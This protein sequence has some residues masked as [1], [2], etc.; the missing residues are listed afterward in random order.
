MFESNSFP[1]HLNDASTYRYLPSIGFGRQRPLPRNAR[2]LADGGYPGQIP[3]VRPHRIARNRLQRTANRKLRQL[4]VSIEHTIG[5]VKVYKSVSEVFRQKRSFLPNVVTTC[6]LL[7]NRRK[8]LILRARALFM[9]IIQLHRLISF[10]CQAIK[11]RAT[12]TLYFDINT[13]KISF[14][15]LI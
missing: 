8:L 7:T 10:T 3:L 4:R 9:F 6:G 13:Q 1:G 2:I 12:G 5:A 15:L 14:V 11:K